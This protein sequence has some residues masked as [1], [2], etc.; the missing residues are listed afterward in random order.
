[1]LKD[2]ARGASYFW[3][4]FPLIFR[5]KIRPFAFAP[6][7]IT[8]ALLAITVW[9][10]ALYF[11]DLVAWSHSKV[12]S[13]LDYE[14]A[15]WLYWALFG[16]LWLLAWVFGFVLVANIV[17]APFNGLL[18]EAVE[19]R[20]TGRVPPETPWKRT[21]KRLPVIAWNETKKLLYFVLWAVPFALASC[22][23][24]VFAP[25]I[26]A[27]FSSWMFAVE[28]CDYPMDNREFP[29][30][31][32]RRRVGKRWMTSLGFGA[33]TLLAFSVPGLNLIAMPVAVAGATIYWIEEL[34]HVEPAGRQQIPPQAK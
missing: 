18:S 28:F 6:L 12:P 14:W 20:L 25:F 34:Q 4:G 1:M 23:L 7:A 17:A 19:R 33:S 24:N 26:W 13:W 15:D 21:L 3:Q 32:V 16:V 9:L 11:Q 31:E 27:W 2:F 10:S 30:R 29:F 8:I 5:P 22:A